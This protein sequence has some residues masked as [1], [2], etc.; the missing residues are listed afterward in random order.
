MS[1]LLEVGPQAGQ[2]CLQLLAA[3]DP[4]MVKVH[5]FKHFLWQQAATGAAA[6][7]DDEHLQLCTAPPTITGDILMYD[8]GCVCAVPGG[9][10]HLH[11]LVCCGPAAS[12]A[13]STPHSS[14]IAIGSVKLLLQAGPGGLA[15]RGPAASC[16]STR[17]L[18]LCAHLQPDE[19]LVL[20]GSRRGGGCRHHQLERQAFHAGGSGEGTQAGHHVGQRALRSS[21]HLLQAAA[22]AQPS[23]PQH[24][25]PTACLHTCSNPGSRP[26]ATD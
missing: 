24:H 12:L 23:P 19:L 22:A 1:R 14:S 15:A 25:P 11:L 21:Q 2:S 26:A 20:Q 9:C 17:P 13:A 8:V 3:D 6:S 5:L 10:F 4:I 16:S 18:M 7:G